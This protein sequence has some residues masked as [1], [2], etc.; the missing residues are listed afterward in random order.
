MYTRH[1]NI[2]WSGNAS[3]ALATLRCST[4]TAPSPDIVMAAIGSVGWLGV[5]V[6]LVNSG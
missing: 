4:F 5:D 3:I 2:I 1:L 6:F